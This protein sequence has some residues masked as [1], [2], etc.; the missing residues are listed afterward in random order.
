MS[1]TYCVDQRNPN[2]KM[3]NPSLYKAWPN[4]VLFNR[5]QKKKKNVL[6]N[7]FPSDTQVQK[8]NDTIITGSLLSNQCTEKIKIANTKKLHKLTKTWIQMR[9]IKGNPSKDMINLQRNKD[10]CKLQLI[11][12]KWK[13]V[14]HN[15]QNFILF[16]QTYK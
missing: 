15:I 12:I 10:V 8:W 11:F 3:N 7:Q 5:F 14:K 13:Q 6:F 16:M 4:N 1:D 9:I 2:F